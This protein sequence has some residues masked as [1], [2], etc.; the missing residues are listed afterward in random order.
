MKDYG[1]DLNTNRLNSSQNTAN[2]ERETELAKNG[3]RGANLLE[4]IGGVAKET[5]L[6]DDFF[7]K[8]NEPDFVTDETFNNE[9]KRS[10]M[11][12]EDIPMDRRAKFYNVGSREEWDYLKTQ[13][14]EKE[15]YEHVTN[16]MSG[17]GL[18]GTS[19]ATSVFSP[20]GLVT[21]GVANT[22]IKGINAAR[23]S[24]VLR[25]SNSM[26]PKAQ[27]QTAMQGDVLGKL[28]TSEG[29]YKSAMAVNKQLYN[30]KN[31]LKDIGIVTGVSA[32]ENAVF[33]AALVSN[34]RTLDTE[35]K[36]KSIAIDA[37][38]GGIF[39]GAIGGIASARNLKKANKTFAEFDAKV[40]EMASNK[41]NIEE[42]NKVK[43]DVFN[44][45]NMEKQ[46]IL[47]TEK[48]IEDLMGDLEDFETIKGGE[49][50]G[51]QSRM[52]KILNRQNAF[53]KISSI[54]EIKK[55]LNNTSKKGFR[56]GKRNKK[57]NDIFTGVKNYAES[58]RTQ[59]NELT[60]Y[61]N[62][63]F[64]KN[65]LV[66]YKVRN[67]KIAKDFAKIETDLKGM[68]EELRQ[69]DEFVKEGELDVLGTVKKYIDQMEEV[70]E[71][72]SKYKDMKTNPET[73]S[74]ATKDYN[75]RIETETKN[76][77]DSYK[78]LKEI[79]GKVDEFKKSDF[80][81][82]KEEDQLID[83][84][85][86]KDRADWYRYMLDAEKGDLAEG[87]TSPMY[88]ENTPNSNT[89][90]PRQGGDIK[91]RGYRKWLGF[92]KTY[93]DK[94][95]E[96]SPEI[97]DM[98]SKV[99]KINAASDGRVIDESV[100]EARSTL[101]AK[102]QSTMF[103]SMNKHIEAWGVE[104][105]HNVGKI[106]GAGT[107][108]QYQDFIFKAMAEGNVGKTETLAEIGEVYGENARKIMQSQIDDLK[109]YTNKMKKEMQDSGLEVPEDFGVDGYYMPTD[110]RS[111]YMVTLGKSISDDVDEGFDQLKLVIKNAILAR[112][113]NAHFKEPISKNSK[114]TYAD[115]AAEAFID[116]TVKRAESGRKVSVPNAEQQLRDLEDLLD[117]KSETGKRFVAKH[118]LKHE[119]V[120][121]VL[122]SLRSKMGANTSK[123]GANKH[124][125]K[126]LEMDYS[127]GTEITFKDGEVRN[128]KPW[129][130]LSRNSEQLY[131]EYNS[132][133][134]GQISFTKLGLYSYADLEEMMHKLEATIPADKPELA[135]YFRNNYA[136]DRDTSV[137]DHLY[138]GR[139]LYKSNWALRE[140]MKYN[141]AT[142]LMLLPLT[143]MN[144]NF[145][146]A[147]IAGKRSWLANSKAVKT[148]YQDLETGKITEEFVEEMTDVGV[149]INNYNNSTQ[150]GY[151]EDF[152]VIGNNVDADVDF[153]SRAKHK[154]S[155]VND[156]LSTITNYIPQKFDAYMRGQTAVLATDRLFDLGLH[157]RSQ[158]LKRLKKTDPSNPEIQKLETQI[159]DF[160]DQFGVSYHGRK[161]SS[162]IVNEKSLGEFGLSE[163]D[164][165]RFVEYMQK[166]GSFS[167]STRPVLVGYKLDKLAATD[168]EL[169]NR[170]V[171]G[172]TKKVIDAVIQHNYKGQSMAWLENN[173][174]AKLIFQFRSHPIQAIS[175]HTRR[176]A[177]FSSAESTTRFAGYMA[178]TIL[179]G[180]IVQMARVGLS[181]LGY[182][183]EER[184]KFLKAELDPMRLSFTGLAR[185]SFPSL[186]FDFING[187]S[188]EMT[189]KGVT[190]AGY[191]YSLTDN[192]SARKAAAGLDLVF[193]GAG[194]ALEKLGA[195]TK[196]Y[197]NSW[198]RSSASMFW[199]LNAP[200]VKDLLSRVFFDGRSYK[201]KDRLFENQRD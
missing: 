30:R 152:S 143:Q 141:Q 42:V 70:A 138:T 170:A 137:I 56:A 85:Y 167:K 67:E 60:E 142:D 134:A 127:K 52:T 130:M 107:R 175:N 41:A 68:N 131:S 144:E 58:L 96:M 25:A 187:A 196:P 54:R 193:G 190:D 51:G 32:V 160:E 76:L 10:L 123:R 113:N 156:K 112:P 111:E 6:V 101:E 20:I 40:N 65:Q 128:V 148:F 195:D 78:R 132:K 29:A 8:I 26:V 145:L 151:A 199:G 92:V 71:V 59:I 162:L 200:P 179:A 154:I 15:D 45:Y 169:Y 110:W 106:L 37:A 48:L 21:G 93:Y 124:L 99:F 43:E 184:E 50:S 3:Y 168:P 180:S 38:V 11:F 122:K 64:E 105:N 136:L 22:A 63:Y 35:E 117:I 36:L 2:I 150:S 23:T 97:N 7:K 90:E 194:G 178:N 94:A 173:W 81:N 139:P 12:S 161:N 125:N 77:N 129:D 197:T 189:G 31:V 74:Q 75:K 115:V 188:Y 82:Y 44:K 53:S 181:S 91:A 185:S 24:N 83:S 166:N 88:N 27:L 102:F 177:D 171:N 100:E 198:L 4:K 104:T 19:L 9:T 34:D 73:Y 114:L 87:L 201:D 109:A 133:V 158:K 164:A 18:L 86:D 69:L 119:E 49:N 55:I 1:V 146:M 13:F 5:W 89:T 165:I 79:E 176:Y 183:G 121:A 28:I 46:N 192:P 120:E 135:A 80:L 39:G 116:G 126:R 17:I 174:L 84:M 153:K 95:H 191:A 66:H 61:K 155:G 72:N 140:L 47:E 62:S 98:F 14:K 182:E 186:A 163:D 16:Q 33:S 118:G 172:Y 149:V 147:Q 159:K 57:A 157:L 108:A 103:R